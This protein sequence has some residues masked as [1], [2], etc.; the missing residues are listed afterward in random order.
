M[1]KLIINTK[2]Y[3]EA[4][5]SNFQELLKACKSLQNK[6]KKLNVELILVPQLPELK[7]SISQVPTYAQH[8]DPIDPGSHTGFIPPQTLS[9]LGCRGTLLNH[10]EHTLPLEVLKKSILM[11]RV[12][13]LTTCVCA[14]TPQAVKKIVHLEPDMIALEPPELIGGDISISTAKP[15]L[16]TESLLISQSIPLL[17]GA[18]VKTT[19]DV[20]KAVELGAKGILV[21]SGVVKAQNKKKAIEELLIGFST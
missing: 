7:E 9:Q 18:G 11:A 17:V 13:G 12:A 4:S 2:A 10:S 8:C 21:A 6:A 19:Q 15:E 5:G 3:S 1:Y 20:K 16:I 14:R